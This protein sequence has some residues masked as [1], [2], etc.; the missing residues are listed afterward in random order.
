MTRSFL[1]GVANVALFAGDN[2]IANSTTLIDSSFTI[3]ASA[4]DVRGGS[5]NQLL[6]KYFHTST[7]DINLTDTL[8]LSPGIIISMPSARVISPVTSVVPI[9]T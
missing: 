9:N 2:L 7:F 3:G 1:A 5:G 4:E 6:G 8:A